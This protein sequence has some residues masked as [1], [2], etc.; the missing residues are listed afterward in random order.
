M[1][2]DDRPAPAP[3]RGTEGVH[4]LARFRFESGDELDA[5]CVGFVTHGT[6]NAARDNAILILPGTG[7][8]RHSADGYIGPGRA[9]DTGRHFVIATDAIGAGTSSKPSDGRGAGFPRY[10]VRDMARAAQQLVAER[11]GITRLAAAAGASMGAF[12]SLELAIHF[13]DLP[14]AIVLL[15][16]AARSGSVMRQAVRAMV[17][18]ITLDPRWQGGAYVDAPRAG[19]ELAGRLYY[20]WTVTD[21]H[22]ESLDSAALEAEAQ[23]NVARSAAWDAWDLIRRYEASAAHDVGAP[24][25]GDVAGALARVRAA[26]LV[27]PVATDRLLGVDSARAIA[28]HVARAEY[29]EVP[30][31]RGHLGWRAIAGA[32]ETAFI[33]RHVAAFLARAA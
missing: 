33:D 5:L 2:H 9:F 21:A 12:Q 4:T 23:V 16:P 11:F 13:P 32:P 25:G 27:M 30:S 26:A 7:N 29:V 28:R 8:T 22:L 1:P 3:S 19:L 10:G 18:A 24:F 20:P 15:V 6:L 14:R 31:A 17:A